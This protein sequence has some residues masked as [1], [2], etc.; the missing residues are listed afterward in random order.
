LRVYLLVVMLPIMCTAKQL[1]P[2]EQ[3]V[4]LL[5]MPN[6]IWQAKSNY[7]TYLYNK[8]AEFQLLFSLL[9]GHGLQNLRYLPMF[10]GLLSVALI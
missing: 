8:G 2:P 5:W 9:H 6:A 7:Q 3:V 4:W 10:C 1:L